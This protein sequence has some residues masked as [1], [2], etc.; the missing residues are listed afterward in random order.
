MIYKLI[1]K[2][3]AFVS[4]D[5]LRLFWFLGEWNRGGWS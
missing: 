3:M 1:Y 2:P 5:E 4:P